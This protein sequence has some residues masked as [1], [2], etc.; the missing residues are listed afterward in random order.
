MNKLTQIFILICCTATVGYSQ[1]A[2]EAF[3]LATSDPS[4]TARNLGTGNSMYNIGPDLSAIAVNPAGIGAYWKSEFSGTLGLSFTSYDARIDQDSTLASYRSNTYNKFRLPN[5]GFVVVTEPVG[6][7]WLTSNWVI[8]INRVA[9]YDKE[10]QFNGY[11]AGSITDSWRERAGGLA[12]DDLN[13]FEEGLAWTSGAI[14]DFE[15]DHIYETDYQSSP[16]NPIYKEENSY[17]QG[18]KSEL[19]LGYGAN[20][21]QKLLIGFSLNLPLVNAD[22]YRN[23]KESDPLDGT[24]FF[25]E[26]E[27]TTTINTSGY[28]INGKFGV[29]LKPSKYINLSLAAHTPTRFQLTDNFN[30]TL[31]YDYTDE[32]HDGPILSESPYG[33]FNYAFKTPWKIAGG[34][35]IIA[36]NSGFVSA[37]VQ[38][39]DYSAMKYDYSVRGNGNEYNQEEREVNASIKTNYGPAIQ[40]NLGGELVV[41]NL[42]FR[43]GVGLTQSAFNNDNTFDPNFNAGVGYRGENFFADLGYSYVQQDEGYLPYETVSAPQP[44]AVLDYTTHRIAATVGMKF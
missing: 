21:D 29:I 42:R 26:L 20:M 12:S 6:S 30:T 40:L 16:T 14:Y 35:G 28:G 22:S 15:G 17:V 23:Y 19:F 43:A 3:R 36:G 7:K 32:N 4:G 1:T 41:T 8:G 39:A 37:G 9:D 18:G 44:L 2:T 31:S 38:W 5:L 33:S 25:N 34:I 24:V 27:Y 11:T 10:I 13:G